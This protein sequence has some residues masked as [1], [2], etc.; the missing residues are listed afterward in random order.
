MKKYLILPI[1]F[2]MVLSI[3]TS[4]TDKDDYIIGGQKNET[5]FF[6]E[7]SFDVLSKMEATD[8][9][10]MLFEKAGLKDSVNK[11]NM[12]IIAPNKWSVSRYLRRK[13]NQALRTNPDAAPLTIEDIPIDT[14]QQM[15]M[16][17]IPGK[18]WSENIPVEGV[19]L[20]TIFGNKLILSKEEKHRP[21]SAWDGGGNPGYGYQYSNFL[22]ENP[23]IIHVHFKR[24]RRWEM[25]Y[26]RR[27]A[28]TDYYD[29]PEC[30]HLYRMYVSD[31]M[32][33]NGVIHVIYQGDYDFKDHYYYH[34]LFFFGTRKDDKL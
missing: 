5:N 29:N 2:F 18:W 11:E 8:I 15:G 33:R 26:S 22:Q 32:T 21:A 14:L 30:D 34:T 19:E 6:D 10:A 3:F 24:G 16:Y 28:L 4:C 9:V 1:Q 25:T 12:T 23:Y 17:I 13:H 27:S 20:T 31:V 7:S